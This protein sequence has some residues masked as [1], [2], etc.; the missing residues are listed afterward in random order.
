MSQFY[1][2]RREESE[3]V[4]DFSDRFMELYNTIPPGFKPPLGT[5]QEY[6]IESFYRE[7]SLSLSEK[8]SV[9]L[10]DMMRDAIEVE[11]NLTTAREKGRE[12]R[13]SKI[14]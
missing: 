7:F 8:R 12:E 6:Y 14:E 5:A 9:S 4:Q 2:I 1:S 13:K 11:I 10:E 3:S